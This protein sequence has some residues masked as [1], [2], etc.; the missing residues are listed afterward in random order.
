MVTFANCR[1]GKAQ[2]R[3][4]E[5]AVIWVDFVPYGTKWEGEGQGGREEQKQSPNTGVF[6]NF[7]HTCNHSQV[8]QI[9]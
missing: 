2:Q 7:H 4:G 9:C 1:A 5:G 3:V 8:L 6:P